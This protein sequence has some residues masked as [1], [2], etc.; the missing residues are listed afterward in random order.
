MIQVKIKVLESYSYERLIEKGFAIIRNS[1]NEIIKGVDDIKLKDN[2]K[3]ILKD[4]ETIASI[5][6]INEKNYKH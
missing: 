5:E 6:E 1:K 2:I 3:I 4:G